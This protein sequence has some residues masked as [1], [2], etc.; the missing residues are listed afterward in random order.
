MEF[1]FAALGANERYRLMIGCIVPRPI[2]LVTSMDAEGRLNAAPYSFFN[3]MS[4]DP[5]LVVIGIENRPEGGPKDTAHNVRETGTF[6]VNLV[7][8]EM[9][10]KM[11]VCA[12]DFPAGVDEVRAAGFTPAASVKVPVPR[13]AEAPAALECR[14]FMN[15]EIGV[16]RSILIGEVLHMYI[17]DDVVDAERLRIDPGKLDL[18]GRLGGMGYARI[19]DR[20]DIK[21]INYAQWLEKAE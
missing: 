14:K 3:A 19:T 4:Q 20:Y 8:H 13:I 12:I 5:P 7:S 21:R 11:N 1:D 16:S 10:E 9:G 6:V 2:A 17:R 15:L 18:I